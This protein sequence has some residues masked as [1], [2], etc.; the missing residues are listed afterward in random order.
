M[1]VDRRIR[2]C[3][4]APGAW[5]TYAGNRVK[6]GPVTH[7]D[8]RLAPGEL[9]AGKTDVLVGTAT[10]AVRLG[11]VKAFGGRQM[12]AADW[13]RGLRLAGPARLGSGETPAGVQ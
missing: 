5:T 6:L 13:A 4:P 7:T 3:T 10:T 1:G 2:A 12:G 9:R 11:E 8:E